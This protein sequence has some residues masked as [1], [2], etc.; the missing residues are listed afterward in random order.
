MA[1]TSYTVKKG[2]TLGA[3]AKR[4]GMTLKEFMSLNPEIKDPNKIFVG[5]KLRLKAPEPPPKESG[6]P[7]KGKGGIGYNVTYK[8]KP[9]KPYQP[10]IVNPTSK[11]GRPA[12]ALIKED[13]WREGSE[14][15]PE[16][17]LIPVEVAVPKPA[18]PPQP[19][20]PPTPFS[21]TAF[22]RIHQYLDPVRALS[23]R[24]G[25]EP[26]PSM[27]EYLTTALMGFGAGMR[28]GFGPPPAPIDP[29]QAGLT[30]TIE[31]QR[32]MRAGT[33]KVAPNEPLTPQDMTTLGERPLTQTT[34][35]PADLV[36]RPEPQPLRPEPSAAS[37]TP[38]KYTGP[39]LGQSSFG[40]DIRPVGVREEP[41]MTS[42]SDA[43]RRLKH[44]TSGTKTARKRMSEM[45][46][47][48]VDPLFKE[49][50][51]GKIGGKNVV[52]E[53]PGKALYVDAKLKTPQ[54]YK[55]LLDKADTQTVIVNNPESLGLVA[56]RLIIVKGRGPSKIDPQKVSESTE[57]V[58]LTQSQ[59][60]KVFRHLGLGQ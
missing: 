56:P 22:G 23:G 19:A 8:D 26:D 5:Q 58:I 43:I 29:K 27:N 4:Y 36:R 35:T 46:E 3:L 32:A 37:I 16:P 9:G 39:E 2:D 40:R 42:A 50:M 13:K 12:S 21:E 41:P 44:K 28:P 30:K 57:T 59:A 24:P 25:T 1:E 48:S 11:F 10:E 49:A 47:G 31:A 20:P 55:S 14:E 17:V 52:V 51:E 7:I 45:G 53:T 33:R 6:G 18:P 60:A 34:L 38:E 15:K 54:D